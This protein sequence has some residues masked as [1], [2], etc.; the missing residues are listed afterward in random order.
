MPPILGV[1]SK[2]LALCTEQ[3]DAIVMLGFEKDDWF[4]FFG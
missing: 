1:A 2:S 3:E 4:I